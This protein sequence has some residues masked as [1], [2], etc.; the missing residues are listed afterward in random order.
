MSG[1][2]H[3][4]ILRTVSQT[5]VVKNFVL[6]VLV[7]ARAARGP[8]RHSPSS[9]VEAVFSVY[10]WVSAPTLRGGGTRR[11]EISARE[12]TSR[13]EAVPTALPRS[14]TY[15]ETVEERGDGDGC[16]RGSVMC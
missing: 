5:L 2:P 12:Y 4:T 11:G 1:G 13:G 15:P 10:A 9:L 16:M 6:T 7:D 14:A 8:R 3:G